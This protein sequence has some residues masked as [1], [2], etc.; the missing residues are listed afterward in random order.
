MIRRLLLALTARLP[1][2]EI[3]HQGEKF[4]ER[5]YVATLGGWRLYIHRFVASDPDCVHDHPW[6]YGFSLILSGWYLEEKRDRTRVRKWFNVVNGD[7]FHRV[8]VPIGGEAWTLFAHNRRCKAWGFMR[9]ADV[10]GDAGMREGFVYEPL[11]PLP[12]HST[13][14]LTAP[15]GRDI[16]GGGQHDGRLC[17]A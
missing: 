12:G 11:S 10:H 17:L 7:T 14:H 8:I 3:E 5:Y 1:V 6:R 4:M 9:P 13:W 2:E 15:K 16:R